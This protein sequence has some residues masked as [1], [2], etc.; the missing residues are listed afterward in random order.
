MANHY[1]LVV[2]PQAARII[3]AGLGKLPGE[4]MFDLATEL[5][6]QIAEQDA[7][8]AQRQ[9][10]QDRPDAYRIATPGSDEPPTAPE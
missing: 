7:E 6:K 9:A 8:A 2:S 5:R 10:E 4:V 1:V 3:M